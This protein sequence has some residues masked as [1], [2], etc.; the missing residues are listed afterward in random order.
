V[1]EVGHP[2]LDRFAFLRKHGIS[3]PHYRHPTTSKPRIASD[4]VNSRN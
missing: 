1:P 3:A 2:K 4:N